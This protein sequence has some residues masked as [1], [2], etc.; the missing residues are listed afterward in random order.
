MLQV[1]TVIAWLVF[2]VCPLC[3]DIEINLPVYTHV[4]TL[5]WLLLR[6]VD[7]VGHRVHLSRPDQKKCKYQVFQKTSSQKRNVIEMWMWVR[8]LWNWARDSFP[9]TI[10]P[11]MCMGFWRM[12]MW[13]GNKLCNKNQYHLVRPFNFV[14]MVYVQTF[15]NTAVNVGAS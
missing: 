4:L 8:M 12:K 10:L 6:T 2:S 13:Q 7:I 9:M 1:S 3:G 14:I 15:K 11:T 5:F